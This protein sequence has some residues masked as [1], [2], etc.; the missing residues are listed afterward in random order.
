M[1]AYYDGADHL[2]SPDDGNIFIESYPEG[3]IWIIPLAGGRSGVG[4]VVDSELGQRG[5]AQGG[6]DAFLDAQIAQT[7][8]ARDLLAPGTRSDGP[9]VIRDWSYVSSELAGANFVL[10]GDAACFFDPL[11]SS[12]V[13]LALSS[14]VLAAAYVTT[15]LRR[16]E[17][18]APRRPRL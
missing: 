11:F 16:P 12:G 17:M 8:R 6:L 9:H 3:W 13:H 7:T 10:A 5:I 14:G 1:Y 2:A 4:A 15:A 18:T